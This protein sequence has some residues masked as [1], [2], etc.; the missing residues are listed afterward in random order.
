MDEGQTITLACFFTLA[1]L[2]LDL[3]KVERINNIAEVYLLCDTARFQN[4]LPATKLTGNQAHRQV[5]GRNGRQF[6][7]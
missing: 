6:A 7:L 3:R 4:C 2:K 1:K 5:T